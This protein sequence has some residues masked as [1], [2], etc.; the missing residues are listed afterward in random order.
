MATQDNVLDPNTPVA[1]GVEY[2]VRWAAVSG[3]ISDLSIFCQNVRSSLSDG[4]KRSLEHSIGFHFVAAVE[5]MQ[6][7]Q[8]EH[9]DTA[10]GCGILPPVLPFELSELPPLEFVQIVQNKSHCLLLT[11]EDQKIK[12]W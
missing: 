11:W 9:S 1:V 5:E 10:E 8:V 2:V 4:D 7:I 3:F 6:N 12:I